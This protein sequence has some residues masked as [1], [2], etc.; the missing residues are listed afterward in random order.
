MPAEPCTQ[1]ESATIELT[2]EEAY[3][4]LLM[5]MMSPMKLDP[6]AEAALRKIA[7][8]C[9]QLHAEPTPEE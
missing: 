2:P 6:V 1:S 8:A 3:A 4:L 9:R 7:D 5:C